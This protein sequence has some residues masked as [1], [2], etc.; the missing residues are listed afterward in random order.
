MNTIKDRVSKEQRELKDLEKKLK[1][2]IQYYNYVKV[3][4]SESHRK[5][6]VLKVLY[7]AGLSL[8]RKISCK[9]EIINKMIKGVN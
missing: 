2:C 7:V 8:Q 1:T 5:S 6:R 4:Y 3:C 9:K